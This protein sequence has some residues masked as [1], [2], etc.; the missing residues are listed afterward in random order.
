MLVTHAG[1]Q[2]PSAWRFP[3][4]LTALL[5]VFYLHKRF[6]V[7]SRG[8]STRQ[9]DWVQSAALLVRRDAAQAVGYIDPA[10][11]VFSDEV[12]FCKRLHDAG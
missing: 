11:F 6:V 5:T 7:Q 12:D 8:T 4:P 1:R 9:V 2:E 10:F 3:G